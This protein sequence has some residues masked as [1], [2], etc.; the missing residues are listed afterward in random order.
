MKTKGI[1]EAQFLALLQK[2]LPKATQ[3][4][5]LQTLIYEEVI[6]EVKLVKNLSS[7]EKFCETGALPDLEEQ[8]VAEFQSELFSNFG[9]ESVTLTP[10]EKGTNLE[11]EI[12]LEDRTISSKVKI[13][14]T[15]A[16]EEEVKAPFVPFPVT[17][18]EDP[19]L[20]WVLARRENVGP[21]EAARAL[22]RIEEEFWQTKK[23]LQLQKSRVEKN[24]AEFIQHVPAAMLGE[25]G[26]K[27]HYK[28]PE[29]LQTLRLLPGQTQPEGQ[30]EPELAEITL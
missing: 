19:G 20:V 2:V 13:D 11:V 24:F 3:D 29:T 7:F 12:A 14:P 10:D 18:P 5:H 15:I 16:L 6:K 30:T 27:R 23:G 17:L 25:A 22:S 1:N 9:E 28:E 26:L 21:D 8:T 4:A